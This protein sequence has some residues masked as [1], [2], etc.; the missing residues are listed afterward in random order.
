[1]Q[2]KT[3]S[4]EHRIVFLSAQARN[5]F[6]SQLREKVDSWQELSSMLRKKRTQLEY[7]RS[8]VRTL[9]SPVFER[10]LSLLP[11]PEQSRHRSQ[12]ISK[13]RY[14]GQKKAGE[15]TM[16]KYPETFAKGR[17]LGA[18]AQKTKV[19]LDMPLT[20]DLSECIGAWIGD[21]FTNRY[22][23]TYYTEITGDARLDRA[24]H[25]HIISCLQ[26]TY[27][28][29]HPRLDAKDNT[30]RLR[31]ASKAI[32]LL[33][34]KRFGLP[35]GRKGYFLKIPDEIINA[36]DKEI[37]RACVRGIFDTDGSVYLDKRFNPPYIRIE[38]HMRSPRVIES[39]SQILQEEGIP[40]Q[41][42]TGHERLQING[43]KNCRFYLDK[44]GFRN[45]RHLNK[46]RNL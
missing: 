42:N 29:I 41:L 1:M 25:A 30:L 36:P 39:V 34:T 12:V 11:D 20:P 35:K 8:G 3:L 31:I 33:L 17:L 21:G 2:E 44:I 23:A 22:G 26:K 45:E 14:W 4:S 38:L 32:H 40:H 10:L 13:E 19:S 16:R 18:Q 6:F 5:S 37:R 27:P 46:V 15:I 7:Y 24:Y 28:D 9:P 43:R